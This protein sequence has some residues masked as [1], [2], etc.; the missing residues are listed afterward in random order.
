MLIF[1]LIPMF[2]PLPAQTA[3]P[4]RPSPPVRTLIF[5]GEEWTVKRSSGRVGPGPNVFSDS[6]ENAWVDDV[7][8]LHLK[9]TRRKGQ[10]YCAE[11]VSKKSFGY[12]TYRFEIANTAQF[13]PQAVWGL[14]TWH[15]RDPA[16]QHREIDIEF[17]RWGQKKNAN[18]QYVVQPYTR[19]QNITRFDLAGDISTSTHTFRW[20]PDV[21]EFQSWKGSDIAPD[22][23]R[24][25]K[26]WVYRGKDLP[27]AG[28]EN[29]RI[30]LWLFGGQPPSENKAVEVIVQ[31]FV[32]AQSEK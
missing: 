3:A 31:K 28:G 2:L 8:R 5:S 16:F 14:F 13:D 6:E 7:G 23:D 4:P 11:V 15:D 32:F 20:S 1:A 19:P 24:A 21:L 26:S 17:S 22:K 9:I 29:V 10:W 18:A 25:L 27:K 12:G 30:N